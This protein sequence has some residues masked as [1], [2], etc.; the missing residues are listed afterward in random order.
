MAMLVT[1]K[2]V[3]SMYGFLMEF[4]SSYEKMYYVL[5]L[6]KTNFVTL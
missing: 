3:F 4:I 6:L 1:K 2:D 5:N